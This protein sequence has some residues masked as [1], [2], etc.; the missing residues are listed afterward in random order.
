MGQNTLKGI[1]FDLGG[2]LATAYPSVT[3]H[4]TQTLADLGHPIPHRVVA[5]AAATLS[6]QFDDPSNRGWSLSHERSYAFWNEYYTKLLQELR[7][8]PAERATYALH[9]YNKLSKPQ[10][11]A[12]YPDVIPVLEHFAGEGYTL[13]LI[14]NWEAWG[15]DLITYLGIG[16]Y[17]PTQVLS[18][19]VGIEKPDIAIF[20]LALA[21]ANI[22]PEHVLY[23]GDS[24]Q[25]DIEPAQAIGMRAVLIDRQAERIVRDTSS[26]RSLR[27]LHDHDFLQCKFLNSGADG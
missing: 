10:G 5:S 20:T 11:Y 19:C 6:P 24:M 18:G 9:I 27:E 15:M 21:E 4:I 16:R 12:L 17:F 1:F 22:A 14:S 3:E 2:T 7:I 23:V 25:F 13:G 8:S 26:I